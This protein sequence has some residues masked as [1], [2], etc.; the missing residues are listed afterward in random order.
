MSLFGILDDTPAMVAFELD[1]VARGEMVLA[2]TTGTLPLWVKPIT[3]GRNG[4]NLFKATCGSFKKMKIFWFLSRLFK[5]HTHYIVCILHVINLNHKFFFFYLNKK[6]ACKECEVSYMFFNKRST[7]WSHRPSCTTFYFFLHPL[8]SVSSLPSNLIHH[9]CLRSVLSFPFLFLAS[10]ISLLL[11]IGC[12]WGPFTALPGKFHKSGFLYNL[13]A[14]IL[15]FYLEERNQSE[16]SIK[17]NCIPIYKSQTKIILIIFFQKLWKLDISIT[18]FNE[19]VFYPNV[20]YING[21]RVSS[22]QEL[23][24]YHS[25]MH[26]ISFFYLTMFKPIKLWTSVC[27]ISKKKTFQVSFPSQNIKNHVIQFSVVSVNLSSKISGNHIKKL[28]PVKTLQNKLTQLPAVDIQHA[29]AKPTSKLHLFAYVDVWEQSLCSLHSDCASKLTHEKR[30]H[31]QQKL[32]GNFCMYLQAVDINLNNSNYL[33]HCGV[34]S[35]ESRFKTTSIF[36]MSHIFCFCSFFFSFL[37]FYFSFILIFLLSF[38]SCDLKCHLSDSQWYQ[39]GFMSYS[40]HLNL[41]NLMMASNHDHFMSYITFHHCFFPFSPSILQLMF[42]LFLI[43]FRVG[44][45]WES[46]IF[47]QSL[48]HININHFCLILSRGFALFCKLRWTCINTCQNSEGCWI[49]DEVIDEGGNWKEVGILIQIQ[50]QRSK[51]P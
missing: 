33:N 4:Q 23:M 28:V 25:I 44:C 32:P 17:L 6:R 3:A 21:K 18:K 24:G 50:N 38:N 7:C 45:C 1:N 35:Q 34:S 29:P 5:T 19:K 36:D 9:P 41:I 10:H 26:E 47:T 51:Q 12:C 20:L 30:L 16:L 2:N 13:S 46:I 43:Y 22:T 14:C 27:N 49:V 31:Q 8:I 40:S 37:F 15:K 39:L 42:I 11:Q 48:P